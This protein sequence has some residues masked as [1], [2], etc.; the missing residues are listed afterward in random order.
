MHPSTQVL[1]HVTH[2][3]R[4]KFFIILN[5]TWTKE[6]V[7]TSITYL[8]L[9]LPLSL[10]LVCVI[11]LEPLTWEARVQPLGNKNENKSG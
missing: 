7:F 3:S 4:Q 11:A 6:S 2:P 8:F 5:Q 9:Y 10:S 1:L